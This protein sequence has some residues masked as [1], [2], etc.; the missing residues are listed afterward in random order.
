MA[1]DTLNTPDDE[2]RAT[3]IEHLKELRKR[4]LYSAISIIIGL[5]VG[6]VF[7][8][9]TID[10]LLLPAPPNMPRIATDLLENVSVWF[11]VGLTSGVIIAMPSLVYQVFAFIGPGLTKR[12]KHF[13]L[14]IIPAIAIMFFMG[15]AFAYFIALPMMINFLVTFNENIATVMPRISTYINMVTRILLLVGLVFETPLVIMGLAK[16][17]LVSPQWLAARR[18]WWILLSFI[19]AAFITPTMDGLSQTV[20]AIP[21]ILLMELGIILARFVYKKKR[22]QPQAA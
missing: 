19:I 17:G 14:S 3:V 9:K 10:I 11:Q 21:L 18:K 8:N 7:A 5:V 4:I 13:V 2:G 20:L 22:D 12:E 6:M 16:L 15:V 1:E